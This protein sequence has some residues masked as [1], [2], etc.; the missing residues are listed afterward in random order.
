ME[1]DF[2]INAVQIVEVEGSS[3]IPT[4]L[5]YD[6]SKSVLIGS[7]ALDEGAPEVLS[8]SMQFRAFRGEL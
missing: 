8:A 6:R 1:K 7:L 2:F 4:V 3:N 5:L